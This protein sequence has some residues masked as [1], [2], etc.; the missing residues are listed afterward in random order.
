MLGVARAWRLSLVSG[1]DGSF[2]DCWYKEFSISGLLGM[3]R[4]WAGRGVLGYAG[5][6][7]FSCVLIYGFSRCFGVLL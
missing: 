1:F 7:L 2:G 6:V 5:R 3:C 4:A